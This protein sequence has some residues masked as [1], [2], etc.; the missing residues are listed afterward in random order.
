ML[1]VTDDATTYVWRLWDGTFADTAT[2]VPPGAGAAL[3]AQVIVAGGVITSIADLRTFIEPAL[4]EL[5]MTRR[6]AGAFNTTLDDFDFDEAPFD[7]MISRVRLAIARKG[8]SASGSFRADVLLR[9]EGADLGDAGTS[10]YTSSGTSD[11]RPSIAHDATDLHAESIDHEVIRGTRGQRISASLVA[12][13]GTITIDP[14][15]VRVTV[16]LRKL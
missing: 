13:P 9:D 6:H 5:P 16:F 7:F 10:I 14:L 1:N 3:L 2:R 12:V 8:T 4:S 11:Q 15:D